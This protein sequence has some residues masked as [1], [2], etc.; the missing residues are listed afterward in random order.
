VIRALARVLLL[1][2]LLCPVVSLA[3]DQPRPGWLLRTNPLGEFELAICV[4]DGD[5]VTSSPNRSDAMTRSCPPTLPNG[6]LGV[7]AGTAVLAPSP[8]YIAAAARN[9]PYEH[10][11]PIFVP[12]QLVREGPVKSRLRFGKR[13]V[14]VANQSVLP[15]T[16]QR[17][18]ARGDV[19]LFAYASGNGL[20]RGR[21]LE[22]G[23]A[24]KVQR[25]L[26]GTTGGAEIV[27]PAPGTFTVLPPKA[28]P[29]TPGSSVALWTGV[30]TRS[31]DLRTG[32]TTREERR[33]YATVIRATAHEVL[34][35]QQGRLR[36][37]RKTLCLP[38]PIRPKRKV[39]RRRR[40]LANLTSDEM[41]VA[42]VVSG[43]KEG[44]YLLLRVGKKEPEW[45][46]IG[47]FLVLP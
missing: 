26:D 30:I 25:L 45:M 19:V 1:G 6:P 2:G 14:E 42:R 10:D 22:G 29:F 7:P 36:V 5:V 9:A 43:P 35:L 13:E 44:H 20:A 34:V 32:E 31:T 16:V 28:P 41:A 39:T 24:P 21:V 17:V 47:S 27:R 18:A 15:L 3:D 11:G 37:H 4:V 38:L 40:V 12:A 46:G 8:A 23:P 33:Y